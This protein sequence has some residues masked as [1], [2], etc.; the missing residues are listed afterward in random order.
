MPAYPE[1][2]A[3]LEQAL[4]F[5]FSD[6]GLL[7][8]ALVHRSYHHEHPDETVLS[9][10]RLEFLGDAVLGMVIAQHLYH[11]YPEMSEGAMTSVRAAVVKTPTLARLGADL[12][13]G[14]YMLMSKGEEAGGGRRRPAVLA[15]AYEALL[16]AMLIDRGLD[17]TRRFIIA[18]FEPIV[19]T[20]VRDRQ[21]KDDKTLL[22]EAV[23][24][25]LGITP[26]YTVVDTSGPDHE[27]LFTVQVNVENT[28][29]GRG[30]G[31]NKREAE[32]LAAAEGLTKLDRMLR[33]GTDGDL[34]GAEGD[35][36]DVEAP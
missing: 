32:Q 4:G 18:R 36:S 7:I 19:A 10:E 9:N 31:H 28:V 27:P 34:S 15:C 13:L 8:Q 29:L 5:T 1:D 35:I 16:G 22:Q 21:F 30:V 14:D 24:G 33:R 2:P 25:L 20:V 26:R 17:D 3:L 12:C 23:Q 6:R 11:R